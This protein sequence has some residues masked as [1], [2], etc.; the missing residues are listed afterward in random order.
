[1]LGNIID[2]SS[3]LNE[4]VRLYSKS[5]TIEAKKL[6]TISRELDRPGGLGFITFILPIICGVTFFATIELGKDQML[7]ANPQQGEFCFGV[8]VTFLDALS[9]NHLWTAA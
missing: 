9:W 2:N 7:D 8:V 6:V 1:M 5:R 4:A 3:N